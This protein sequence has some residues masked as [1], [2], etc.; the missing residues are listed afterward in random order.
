M[1][2]STVFLFEEPLDG[3]VGAGAPL[4]LLGAHLQGGSQSDE[5]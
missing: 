5:C 4:L 2:Q 1:V 3:E